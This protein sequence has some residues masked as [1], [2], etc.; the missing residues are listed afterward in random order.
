MEINKA[1]VIKLLRVVDCILFPF[2]TVTSVAAVFA[3]VFVREVTD[4]LR[5]D[6]F[7]E[8]IDQGMEL[9]RGEKADV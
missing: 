3:L 6:I 2:V 5:T 9:N 4:K 7:Y 8:F 1:L